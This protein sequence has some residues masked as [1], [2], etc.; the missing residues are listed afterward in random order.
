[1]ELVYLQV[2]I[3]NKIKNDFY[4]YRYGMIIIVI[5]VVVSMNEVVVQ[6]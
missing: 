6:G 1:M 2:V 4:V 3:Y 5:V